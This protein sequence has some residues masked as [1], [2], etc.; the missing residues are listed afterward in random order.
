MGTPSLSE[1]VLVWRTDPLRANEDLG[2]PLRQGTDRVTPNLSGALPP[3]AN[4]VSVFFAVHAD[5]RWAEKAKLEI[6]VLRDG[7]LLGDAP[8]ISQQVGETEYSSYLSSFSINPPKDGAYQVKVMLSQG[9]KPAEANT[10]FTLTSAESAAPD[11]MG[12]SSAL[13]NAS[14]PAGPLVITPATNP[15]QRPSPDELKSIIAAATQYATDYWDSLPN[16]ICE[17]VTDRSVSVDGAKTWKHKD[18]V[19]GLLTYFDH[20]EDW[21]YLETEQDGHKRHAGDD[22]GSEKGISSAGLFGTVIRGLFR[23]ASKA[24]IVWKETGVLG[25]GTVQVFN[26]RVAREN[27][28]LNLRVAAVQVITVGYHGLVYIDSTTHSVRRITEIADDVPQKYP[29]HATFVSADYDYVSI[30]SHDYLM[31]VGAQVILRKGRNETDLNEIEFHNF[32]RFGSTVKILTA[33]P[34]KDK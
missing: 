8:V 16:F 1:I 7:K 12:D 26:Y 14:L 19:S 17:E 22:L 29:I 25:D 23:P 34:E 5:P 30:G 27:S 6:Q 3:G 33:S 4:N 10:T 13:G 21:S 32:H 28:T 20:A 11:E 2:E 15:I 31:P 18:K 24:E 9:G